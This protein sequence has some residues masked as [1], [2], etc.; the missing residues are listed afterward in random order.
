MDR[1]FDFGAFLEAAGDAI[2]A[3]APDGKIVFW[4]AAAER[5]FG[6]RRSEALGQS[7][8]L[9]IPERFRQRHWEGY[10]RVMASG[11]TRYGAD[12]L[13]VPALHKGGR[14]L[15]ISFTVTLM[16]S[17]ARQI[18]AMV[19]IVRDETARWEEE[20]ALRKRVAELEAKSA[21]EQ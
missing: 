20:Q 11:E 2:V 12:V 7:L 15:S 4:N 9:I 5:I 14:R 17:P 19:A 6:Y 1:P 16:R 10:Q 3:A 13:R 21:G 18:E 8:D